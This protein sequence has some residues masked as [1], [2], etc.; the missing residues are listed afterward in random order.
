[1][2][3]WLFSAETAPYPLVCTADPVAAPDG[4]RIVEFYILNRSRE[5]HSGDQLQ[6]SLNEALRGSGSSPSAAIVLN[7]TGGEGR[8]EGAVPDAEFNRGKGELTASV[9]GET[10]RIRIGRINGGSLLRVNI[11]L[12]GMA[13]IGPISRDAK[14]AVPF[15][16]QDIQE[17]C[18]TRG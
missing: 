18:Y 16:Y 8:I 4:R 12:A 10:V 5:D 17:A 3:K 11:V 9:E 1:M 6:Q 7:L 13:D 15:D 14:V 2:R